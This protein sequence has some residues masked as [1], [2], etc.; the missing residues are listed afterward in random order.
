MKTSILITGATGYLGGRLCQFLSA[1][2]SFR[3]R[4][5]ARR[6]GDDLPDWASTFEHVGLDLGSDES[7]DNACRNID[8]VIHL[9]AI[10]AQESA[11]DPARANEV[12]VYG[13]RQL[14]A[15]A[16]RAGVKRAVYISTI[17][18]YGAPLQGTIDES[19]LPRPAHP[20]ASTHL[21]A[22]DIVLAEPSLTGIVLRLSNLLGAPADA[23][24]NCWMLVANDLCRQAV[25]EKRIKLNGDGSGVRD[26][27]CM[28]DVLR[29]L[30]HVARLPAVEL[31]VRLF[32]VG[33]GSSISIFA[34][35]QR[36]VDRTEKIF[37]YRPP[38]VTGQ[39]TGVSVEP[40]NYLSQRI[41][42]T[43]FQYQGNLNLELDN[44]LRFCRETT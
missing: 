33:A 36:I 14:V 27:V 44:T 43:G 26:F 22:E 39:F 8:V 20:Y 24:A 32:N 40:L 37:L 12:N 30:A 23:G 16:V 5:A 21:A 34:L 9:A 19:T 4:I 7:L 25:R 3:V 11:A 10:N 13:T 41:S 29:V 35:A 38:V 1:A 15:A 6:V 28:S 42:A 18:V 31:G 2:G 17:H